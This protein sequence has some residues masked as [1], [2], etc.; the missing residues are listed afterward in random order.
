MSQADVLRV[1]N[2]KKKPLSCLE[3]SKILGDDLVHVSHLLSKLIK[4]R[5]I[6][7]IEID[8]EEARKKYNC[9]QR[10]RLFYV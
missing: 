6:K 7:V 8:K 2:K 4:H 3:I 10:M 1:L 5:D 9:K